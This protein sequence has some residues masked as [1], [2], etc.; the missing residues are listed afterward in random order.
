MK[1]GDELCTGSFPQGQEFFLAHGESSGLGGE[2]GDWLTD[3]PSN[4]GD[5]GA[6]VFTSSGDVVAI[7]AGGLS[8]PKL[9]PVGRANSSNCDS[10]QEFQGDENDMATLSETPSRTRTTSVR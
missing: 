9:S 5:I 10:F 6:P 4:P 8:S 7:K 1:I 3:M 2:H